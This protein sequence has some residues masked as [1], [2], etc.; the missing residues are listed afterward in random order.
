MLPE[1]GDLLRVLLAEV[2]ALG[3]DDVEELEADGR[4][5]AE[6]PGPDAA[7]SRTAP[8]S[9]T[10]TQVWKPGGYISS[11]DGAKSDV[12][13]GSLPPAPR[14]RSQSRGYASRSAASPNCAGLTK[15]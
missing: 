11:A 7:P 15:S 14:S 13:A 4:D 1:H 6:V 5:A 9:V 3:P 8:S 10:S 2:G 12:D